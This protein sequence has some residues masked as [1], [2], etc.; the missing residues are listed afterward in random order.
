M[1]TV[2]KGTNLAVM[3]LLELGVLAAV[4]F[5]GFTL[6]SGVLVRLPAG[7]GGP[8]LF[9]AVWAIFGAANGARIP[10]KGLSRAALEVLWFGGAA[11]AL[12]ASGHPVM[13]SAFAVVYVVNAV[14]RLAWH[15]TGD[16]TVR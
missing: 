13:G 16:H 4:G 8:A 15:Q 11:V 9:V 5:W 3:F 6:D 14:L 12:A 2:A 10:L 7:I 1:L